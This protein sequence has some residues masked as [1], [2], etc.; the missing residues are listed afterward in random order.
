M[1]SETSTVT[2]VRGDLG[3]AS[4]GTVSL[5]D[6]NGAEYLRGVDEDIR[7]VL[8]AGFSTLAQLHEFVVECGG[9]L[10]DHEDVI[11]IIERLCVI[12]AQSIVPYLHKQRAHVA[13]CIRHE[14][15]DRSFVSA[16]S[17]QFSSLVT[18]PLDYIHEAIRLYPSAVSNWQTVEMT[19][20]IYKAGLPFEYAASVPWVQAYQTPRG[21]WPR[22]MAQLYAAGV[23]AE[24]ARAAAPSFAS[25]ENIISMYESGVHVEYAIEVFA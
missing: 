15:S 10:A 22:E 7:D 9:N 13:A 12:D 4:G 8:D 1:E 3:P 20:D 25:I 19:V 5:F 14:R 24:F 21:Y 2:F 6:E 18:L 17:N 16:W 11:D 23:P